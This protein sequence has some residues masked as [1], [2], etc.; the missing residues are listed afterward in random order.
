MATALAGKYVIDHPW[1]AASMFGIGALTYVSMDR[2]NISKDIQNIREKTALLS[3]SFK[4]SLMVCL[5]SPIVLGQLT[6]QSICHSLVS[7]LTMIRLIPMQMFASICAALVALK[8]FVIHSAVPP[9]Q[10]HYMVGQSEASGEDC[11]KRV[12]EVLS[13]LFSAVSIAVGVSSAVRPQ[14]MNEWILVLTKVI[15]SA[16]VKFKGLSAFFGAIF[17]VLQEMVDW[18]YARLTRA[19]ITSRIASS[20]PEVID[21]WIREVQILTKA[22]NEEKILSSPSWL[23]RTLVCSDLGDIIF[24]EVMKDRPAKCPIPGLLK[25]YTDLKRLR[26]KAVSWTTEV[27]V[28]QEPFCYWLAGDPGI[29]KSQLSN[30]LTLDL[31]SAMKDTSV[32]QPIYDYQ[33]GT[34]HWTGC[35]GKIACRFDDFSII[36]GERT[37]EDLS[38]FMRMKSPAI[39]VPEQAEIE[40]KGRPWA[41]KFICVCSNVAFPSLSEVR[42]TTA[43]CR[44]RDVVVSCS[45]APHLNDVQST[46]GSTPTMAHPQ[47]RSQHEEFLRNRIRQ[48]DPDLSM[49]AIEERVA[50]KIK[51]DPEFSHLIFQVAKSSSNANTAYYSPMTYAEMRDFLIRKC[52][53]YRMSQEAAYRNILD[54]ILSVSGEDD[55]I[56]PLQ[57]LYDRIT[58]KADEFVVSL[59]DESDRKSILQTLKDVSVLGSI[60]STIKDALKDLGG[61]VAGKMQGESD[62]LLD[63]LNETPEINRDYKICG[64]VSPEI[65]KHSLMC[66]CT[67]FMSG[68]RLKNCTHHKAFQNEEI[69]SS[70][71]FSGG[72]WINHQT[73][74]TLPSIC[75][76]DCIFLDKVRMTCLQQVFPDMWFSKLKYDEEWV[77]IDD[78]Q[79]AAESWLSGMLSSLSSLAAQLLNAASIVLRSSAVYFVAAIALGGYALYKHFWKSADT[80]DP[81]GVPETNNKEET[82][83]DLIFPNTE[84]KVG[85]LISSGDPKTSSK[86]TRHLRSGVTVKSFKFGAKAESTSTIYHLLDRNLVWLQ[87][88][89]RDMRPG[90]NG[91]YQCADNVVSSTGKAMMLTGHYCLTLKHYWTEAAARGDTFVRVLGSNSTTAM[92]VPIDSIRMMYSEDSE[93]QIALLPKNACSMAKDIRHH[94]PISEHW[95]KGYF[96]RFGTIYNQTTTCN[97]VINTQFEYPR[98]SQTIVDSNGLQTSCVDGPITYT[99]SGPGKCM[100]PILGIIGGR[101]YVLGFHTAGTPY[102]RHGMA[103]HVVSESF[104]DIT[105][106]V[107]DLEDVPEA[108]LGE[109][110]PAVSV[111]TSVV[112][113]GVSNYS[114]PQASKTKIIQS[115]ICLDLQLTPKTSP[116]PL[117]RAQVPGNSFDPL[118]EGVRLHGLPIIPDSHTLYSVAAASYRDEILIHCLPVA[119]CARVL[120]LDEAVCGIPEIEYKSMELRTSEGYPYIMDRPPGEANKRWL[121]EREVT[122]GR[123]KLLKLHNKLTTVMTHKH[124]LREQGILPLT[125]FVDCLKDSRIPNEKLQKLGATRVFSVS[126]ADYTLQFRQYFGAFDVAYRFHRMK[127]EHAVGINVASVDWTQIAQHLQSEGWTDFLDFDYSKFGPRL[128]PEDSTDFCE[129]ICA[130]YSKYDKSVD[131]EKDNAIRRVMFEEAISSVHL[132]RNLLYRTFVGMPSGFPFT[133][134]ANNASNSKGMRRCWMTIWRND[135]SMCNMVAF[136]KHVKLFCYGDDIVLAISPLAIKS[137][138]GPAIQHYFES[139]DMKITDARKGTDIPISKSFSEIS[140]L[141]HKWCKHPK[142]GQYYLASIDPQSVSECYSW[143]RDDGSCSVLENRLEPSIVNAEMALLLSFGHGPQEYMK[144]RTSLMEW[145]VKYAQGQQC[146]APQFY[147]WDELDAILFPVIS[148]NITEKTLQEIKN[149]YA[150]YVETITLLTVD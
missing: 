52:E 21:E 68:Y 143:I 10:Q 78:S 140:F 25:C 91:L 127:L 103:E 135:P 82:L 79:K 109:S 59:A 73:D 138:N 133:V 139:K 101:Q 124:H 121:I 39:L 119:D 96:P 20:H 112:P 53:D 64:I 84:K 62:A 113:L 65:H 6:W 50:D 128:D 145:W 8:R 130:W 137:F 107:K 95:D 129:T 13:L 61:L 1:K 37:E 85:D 29:G 11:K 34:K 67:A 15:S 31:I 125:V 41:P 16:G 56:Q 33:P 89:Q 58:A 30:L 87:F 26:D 111:D 42:N 48:S 47:I 99:W 106:A 136:K 44:R 94:F 19:S 100:T 88:L 104:A 23:K 83:Q 17:S 14:R 77:K 146:R 55:D 72:V 142:K 126:P 132:A 102:T 63:S 76:V 38:A 141:K 149:R 69:Y 117:S 3:E 110:Q 97:E 46:N 28:R 81:S 116:A 24:R 57:V 134:Q 36:R 18:F 75:G 2:S 9:I 71:R 27:A 32:G 54:R 35:Q 147:T 22:E 86:L 74:E 45:Y 90:D 70:F 92:M 108:M 123:N 118:A 120:T 60:S 4:T 51:Y 40:D 98:I 114:Y 43:F 105:P 66:V 49:E 122:D 115:S 7:F 5:A 150:R 80:G 131:V 148:D 12:G 144:L 93:F